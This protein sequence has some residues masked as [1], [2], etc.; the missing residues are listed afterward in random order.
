MRIKKNILILSAAVVVVVLSLVLLLRKVSFKPEARAP[1]VVLAEVAIVIDDWGY[2]LRYIG[3]LKQIEAPLSISILPNLRYSSRIVEEV[4][5][6]NREVILHLPLEPEIRVRKIGLEKQT[7]TTD[8]SEQEIVRNLELALASLH[9]V[10]GVSNHM[11]SRATK[12]SR[13]MSIIF[14]EL[15]KHKL[16]FLDNLVTEDSICRELAKKMRVKFASRDIFLD[17]SDNYEYIKGQFKQ[18]TEFALENGRAVGIGHP[19]GTTLKILKDEVALMQEKGIKF[20]FISDLV[21]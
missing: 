9:D 16:F 20:V 2:N 15:K 11:G 14:A 5:S 3:L 1:E 12:D 8:M 21:E 4:K 6:L 17:N 7:I 18:L 10:C 19:R 13:L